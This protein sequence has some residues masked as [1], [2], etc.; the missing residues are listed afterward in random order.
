MNVDLA[1]RYG[2]AE[3]GARVVDDAPVNRPRAT[4][5]EAA[6]G[7]EGPL[8][9]STWAG[10]TTKARFLGWVRGELAPLLRAGDVVAMDN[11]SAHRAAGVA[12]A[13]RARGARVLYLPPYSPDL[14]PVEKMWSKM[15]ALLRGLRARD[16][17]A[18]PGAVGWA[19]AQVTPS[20]CAGWFRSCGYAV[21]VP[22]T[23]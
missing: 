21:E 23:A 8:A 16:P 14:N 5:V 7:P 17:G 6:M 4:T 1:R 2:R 9:V 11:L 22:S 10:G 3:G 15:K 12:D 20:D 18:L 19:L 13:V